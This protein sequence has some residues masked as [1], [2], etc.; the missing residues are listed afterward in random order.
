MMATTRSV[1]QMDFTNYEGKNVAFKIV[2]PRE[3]LTS[4]E[5]QSVMELANDLK[6]FIKINGPRLVPAKLKGAK[7]IDTVTSDFNITIE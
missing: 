7:I 3:D 1:L 2:D 4:E 6:V 5:V